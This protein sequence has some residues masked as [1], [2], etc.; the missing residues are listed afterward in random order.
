LF[1]S[2]SRLVSKTTADR[3][4]LSFTVF[5]APIASLIFVHLTRPRPD[6]M[7]ISNLL[8][9]GTFATLSIFSFSPISMANQQS[10]DFVAPTE[11]SSMTAPSLD[12]T[13]LAEPSAE[14][15]EPVQTVAKSSGVSDRQQPVPATTRYIR[16]RY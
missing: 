4:Y 5:I 16:A 12:D 7:R 14:A 13:F 6:P 2:P 9:I 1:F 11:Q 15:I 8:A 10:A 3:H